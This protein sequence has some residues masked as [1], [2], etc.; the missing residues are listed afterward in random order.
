ML[1]VELSAVG[2][3]EGGLKGAESAVCFSQFDN[4]TSIQSDLLIKKRKSQS[5]RL[6]VTPEFLPPI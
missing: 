3:S 2:T 5:V 1:C 6:T 4:S